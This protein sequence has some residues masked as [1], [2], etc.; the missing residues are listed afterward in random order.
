MAE[1]CN[2]LVATLGRLI[3]FVQ[4]NKVGCIFIIITIIIIMTSLPSLPN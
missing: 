3:D 2:F 1:G 4:Q